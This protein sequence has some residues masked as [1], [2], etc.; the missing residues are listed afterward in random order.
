[1]P[2]RIAVSIFARLTRPGRPILPAACEDSV[3][4]EDQGSAAGRRARRR[5]D[6]RIIWSFIKNKLIL[7]YRDVDLKYYDL[8]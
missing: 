7:P 1:L 3:D 4:G 2:L 8:A 6:E 5:R